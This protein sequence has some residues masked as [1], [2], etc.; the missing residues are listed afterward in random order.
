[1]ADGSVLPPSVAARL[2][3]RSVS[4]GLTTCRPVADAARSA[5]RLRWLPLP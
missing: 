3:M 4:Q 5:R 1:M 2:G